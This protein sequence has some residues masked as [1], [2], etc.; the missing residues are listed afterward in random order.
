MVGSVEGVDV[1]LSSASSSSA[2]DEC[3]VYEN[4][5]LV[6]ALMVPVWFLLTC[7]WVWNT[8]RHASA[9]HARDLHRLLCW[10]PVVQLVHGVLSLFNYSSCPWDGTGPLIFATFWAVLTILKEP[11]ML[12][13][14][15]LVA[16]VN[17]PPR[18][19]HTHTQHAHAPV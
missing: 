4:V 15:L 11:L 17:P 13:C 12:L 10:V 14:L 1:S 8:C 2:I 19:A 9:P 18:P 3:A 16:K 5:P 6:F 7:G